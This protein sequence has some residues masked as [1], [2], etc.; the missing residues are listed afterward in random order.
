M[1]R[2]ITKEEFKECYF[3]LGGGDATGWGQAYWDELFENDPRPRMKYVLEEP[4]STA[5]NRMMIVTDFA[6]NEYRMFFLTEGS[7]DSFC[8]FQLTGE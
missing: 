7:E 4:E 8:E 5:H 6:S 3:R 2:E 1:M